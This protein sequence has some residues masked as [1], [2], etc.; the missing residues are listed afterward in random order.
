MTAM[1]TL[2]VSDMD[3]TLLGPDAR[4][5]PESVRMLNVAI[6]GGALF[7]VATARTPATVSGLL[8][9]VDLRIPL[10]VMTGAAL[11]DSR[12]GAY[13]NPKFHK[14]ETARRLVDLYR[15]K[16]LPTFMYLLGEDNLIHIYHIGEMS[17]LERKFVEERLDSPFKTFH[18]PE[19]G[20]SELPERLDR[21]MLFYAMRPTEEVRRV[22]D[23]IKGSDDLR[24]VFY[25]DMY[26]Q[27]IALMEVFGPGASKALA[28]KALAEMTGAGRITAY[29]DNINDLPM[30]AV[31]DEA[32]AVANAVPDV[33]DAAGRV[34]GPNSGDSV[35]KDIL[36]KN[37]RLSDT[38][39]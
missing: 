12:T 38:D 15:E 33:M 19:S 18:I 22:H 13:I 4:V 7:S 11:W 1:K 32:V 25:H 14:E 30:L 9:D 6:A 35:A 28:V 24:A 23:A 26:G 27:E 21:V 10:V 34:I 29:G 2:Y 5:S 8:K 36:S 17:P 39:I 20:D 3:G 37:S 16:G 31:A